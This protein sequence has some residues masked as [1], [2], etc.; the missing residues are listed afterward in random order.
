MKMKHSNS[1]QIDVGIGIVTIRL[2]LPNDKGGLAQ[3][4]GVK[5]RN[6]SLVLQ[7]SLEQAE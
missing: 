1:E 6:I 7:C 5:S 2:Q 4:P 3:K